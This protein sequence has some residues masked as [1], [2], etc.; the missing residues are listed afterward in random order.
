MVV[1]VQSI[2]V[3]GEVRAGGLRMFADDSRLPTDNLAGDDFPLFV[4]ESLGT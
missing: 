2:P 3:L 1:L 4:T